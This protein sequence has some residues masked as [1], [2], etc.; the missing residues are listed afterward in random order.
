MEG[1]AIVTGGAGFIGSHVV[2]RLL[3]AGVE[4]TALDDLSTG[5]RENLAS[6][7]ERGARLEEADV[8]DADAM[9]ELLQNGRPGVV[10]HLAAQVSVTRS[11]REVEFD[12]DVNV[13]GTATVLE[14]ARLAGVP[15]FVYVST[16]GALY[17]EADHV[18]TPEDAPIR[19]DAPYGQ[20]K[21]A[22]ELYCDLYERLHGMSTVTLRLAN[23]YGPRQ[24][25]HGE[26]G[27]VAIFS[28]RLRQGEAPTVFGDGHQTRDYV[29]VAD[30]AEAVLAAGA[31]DVRGA[32]NI[33]RGRQTSVLELV[34]ALGALEPGADFTPE[35]A[36]P[37]PGESQRSCLDPSRAKRELGW[38]SETEL[39][40]GLRVT[41]ESFAA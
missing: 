5:S 15:R 36:P 4:V 21:W 8:R 13:R 26:A 30:V 20:S 34:D 31:S 17:G 14:A 18:P 12:A 29:Y 16:G 2:D 9:R 1:Q 22:G 40:D 11:V 24:D 33:S 32:L 19:P 35:H 28:G 27:V 38:R 37:R 25:P 39:P 7:L 41:Y 3:D 23:I 6:A 10:Y